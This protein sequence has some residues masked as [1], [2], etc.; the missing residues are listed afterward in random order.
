MSKVKVIQPK[1]MF[2]HQVLSS[3]LVLKARSK[4][5][6]KGR[7][8]GQ[9]VK[10]VGQGH[11]AQIMFCRQVCYLASRSRS[12]DGVK[13]KCQGHGSRS[14][15]WCTAVDIRGSALPSAVKSNRS[16]NQ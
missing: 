2:C 16:H 6:V 4:V 14:I 1:I 11:R 10:V 13:V 15:F 5:K 7:D 3:Y 12:N 9:K 8:Q